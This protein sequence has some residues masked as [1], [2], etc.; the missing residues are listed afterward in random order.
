[1]TLMG[2]LALIIFSGLL[3]LV[4]SWYAVFQLGSWVVLFE[5]LEERG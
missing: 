2:V 1:M 5:E 3:L 4:G